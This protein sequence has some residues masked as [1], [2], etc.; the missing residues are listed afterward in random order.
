ML[1]LA[2]GFGSQKLVQDVITGVFIQ[3]ENAMN[4][5]DVV[6]VGDEAIRVAG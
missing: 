6:T 3:L 1:G 5:G 2:I 4:T